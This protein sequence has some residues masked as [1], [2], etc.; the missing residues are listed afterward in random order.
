MRT[1][2]EQNGHRALEQVVVLEPP[3]V[4]GLHLLARLALEDG[5]EVCEERP[6]LE[7]G[8]ASSASSSPASSS[9]ISISAANCA[10]VGASATGSAASAWGGGSSVLKKNQ[11]PPAA[12][13]RS[14]AIRPYLPSFFCSGGRLEPGVTGRSVE[15]SADQANSRATRGSKNRSLPGANLVCREPTSPLWFRL[16]NRQIG[17]D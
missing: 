4:A 14:K 5:R 10:R 13:R 12:R 7:G 15:S 1:D 11:T 16:F 3:L 6:G 9:G 8:G 17:D 2:G